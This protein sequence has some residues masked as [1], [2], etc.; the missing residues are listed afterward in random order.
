M[1]GGSCDRTTTSC[2][3]DDREC[4]MQRGF[5]DPK[6][7]PFL[8]PCNDGTL[9]NEPGHACSKDDRTDCRSS[10]PNLMYSCAKGDTTCPR[11]DS[12]GLSRVTINGR[13]FCA[14]DGSNRFHPRYASICPYTVRTPFNGLDASAG[15]G[16]STDDALSKCRDFCDRRDQRVVCIPPG[17]KPSTDQKYTAFKYGC[18]LKN[19]KRDDVAVLTEDNCDEA[20]ASA[21]KKEDTT[22][23]PEDAAKQP[24]KNPTSC[25]AQ[26][27]HATCTSRGPYIKNTKSKNDCVWSDETCTDDPNACHQY[28]NDHIACRSQPPCSYD[29]HRHKCFNPTIYACSKEIS[30][31]A[32]EGRNDCLWNRASGSCVPK[33]NMIIIIISSILGGLIVIAALTYTVDHWLQRRKILS[34]QIRIN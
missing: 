8:R 26:L 5:H 25:A 33:W 19:S 11:C 24:I 3:T 17:D 29:R 20:S 15:L 28:G 23:E 4:D 34:T 22:P 31:A 18:V 21:S 30:L 7:C 16:L 6:E 27:T 13:A 1:S 9:F 32:C 2:C 14:H 12:R 10:H